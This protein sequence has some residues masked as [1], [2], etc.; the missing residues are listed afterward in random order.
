MR[1][2]HLKEVEPSMTGVDTSPAKRGQDA[3]RPV[4]V[5]QAAVQ[6]IDIEPREMARIASTVDKKAWPVSTGQPP[7]RIVSLTAAGDLD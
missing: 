1:K 4:W 5:R 6:P 3:G 7:A 2:F